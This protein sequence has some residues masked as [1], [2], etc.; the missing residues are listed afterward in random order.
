MK[1]KLYFTF[2]SFLFFA[3]FSFAQMWN[4]KDTL[5]GNEWINYSQ[6]YFKMKIANDGLYRLD[7]KDLT[8]AGIPLATLKGENFKVFALGKEV[9]LFV[10]NKNTLQNT[11]YIEFYGKKNRGELDAELYLKPNVE[12]MNPNFS[13]Y[14]DT[15]SYFLTWGT[16]T[17]TNVFNEISNDLTAA[18]AKETYYLHRLDTTFVS[19]DINGGGFDKPY[20]LVDGD[21]ITKSSFEPAEGFASTY[22]PTRTLN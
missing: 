5:Y 16:S 11:D 17:N 22:A 3:Q 12:Q 9:P 10:S 20:Y 8:A 18:P 14:N 7:A 1:N 15:I 4:G 13:M 19:F 2:L 21:R 6:T